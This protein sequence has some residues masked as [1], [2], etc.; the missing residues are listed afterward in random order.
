MGVRG[1]KSFQLSWALP[2]YSAVPQGVLALVNG[3]VESVNF[4]RTRVA[5]IGYNWNV[6]TLTQFTSRKS[7]LGAAMYKWTPASFGASH[8]RAIDYS[9]EAFRRFGRPTAQKVVVMI[10]DQ[11]SDQ[12]LMTTHAAKTARAQGIT[13]IPVGYNDVFLNPSE[14]VDIARNPYLV[15]TVPN[16]HYLADIT[17]SIIYKICHTLHYCKK[18]TTTMPPTTTTEGTAGGSQPVE[19]VIVADDSES[20]RVFDQYNPNDLQ[21]LNNTVTTADFESCQLA[22]ILFSRTAR[23]LSGL[24]NNAAALA[25]AVSSI[26]NTTAEFSITNTDMGLQAARVLLTSEG[27]P[28][29]VKRIILLTDGEPSDVTATLNEATLAK[30]AGIQI[31]VMAIPQ[32]NNQL[33]Y[34]QSTLQAIASGIRIQVVA[35]PQ[36]SNQLGYLQST[37]EAIASG[38]DD[39]TIISDITQLPSLTPVCPPPTVSA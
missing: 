10:T 14:L 16:D 11:V 18:T 28:L 13:F 21:W 8:Y 38:P 35:I 30:N 4:R 39:V 2:Q 19:V 12:Y 9:M 20:R 33:G 24:S 17:D 26:S 6:V 34:L 22:F 1:S 15:T 27:D 25:S 32:F 23:V 37:M 7:Q 3:L 36:F 29:A 5:I 31:E